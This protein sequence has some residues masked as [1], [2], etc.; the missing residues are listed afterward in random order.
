[1]RWSLLL[2]VPACGF[3][4]RNAARTGDAPPP[5][6]ARPIDGADARDA[7]VTTCMDH[8][9]AHDVRFQPP[10]AIVELDTPD[11]E[12]DPWLTDDELTIYF[13]AVRPDSQPMYQ[14]DIYTAT[15]SGIGDAFGP[16][17]KFTGA[18]T[19]TGA[20]GKMTM[21]GDGTQLFVA[22]NL[23]GSGSK[24]GNDIWFSMNGG[25]GWA[26]LGQGKAGA[27]NDAGDQLDPDI[28]PE[29]TALYFAPT[30]GVPQ[31][32]FV[33]TRADET[34]N[35]DAGTELMELA[36]PDGGGTADPAISADQKLIIVT[37]ARTG[38][39]GVN[40]L[41]YATRASV[42]DP[43]GTLQPVPDVNSTTYDGDAHLSHD[44]CRIYFS[45]TRNGVQA[46][47]WDLFVAAQQL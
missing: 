39:I 27:M 38:T 35:F 28:T 32:I 43:F 45:S 17:T 11:Y 19:T 6:D 7:P 9:M 44:G 22:S 30:N 47:D 2:V 12:R 34:K 16:A 24:G 29:G 10:T 8:W 36:D 42:T 18:S 1:M 33:A 21:T 23:T 40:D 4:A 25:N 31:Q 20:E 13:S 41:F 37:S 15:R 14:Q 46:G 3:S 5:A 26:A